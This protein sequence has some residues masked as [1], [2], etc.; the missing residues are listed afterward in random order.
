MK[1]FGLRATESMRL[2]KGYRHWKADLITEFNPME[3]AL[4]RFVK[5]DKEFTGKHALMQRHNEGPRRRFVSMEVDCDYAVAHPG[6]SVLLDGELCGT[7]TSAAWGYRTGKNLAMAFVHPD[8]MQTDKPLTVEILGGG[9]GV[10]YRACL[11]DPQNERVR[12]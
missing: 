6:D 1:P 11:Y 9:R 2:E 8:V 4:E 12:S 3:T 10:D 7:I 5:L